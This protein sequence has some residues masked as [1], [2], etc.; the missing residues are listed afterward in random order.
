M[1]RRIVLAAL[2][3]ALFAA[4]CP[5]EESS[6]PPGKGA[7]EACFAAHECRAGL[8]CSFSQC[9]PASI[10]NASCQAP[11]ISLGAEV[12]VSDPGLCVTP[13]RTPVLA[14]DDRGPLRVTTPVSFDVAPGT[15]SLTIFSQEIDNTAADSIDL[16]GSQLPNTVVPTGVLRPPG[17]TLFF[18][19]TDP[20][21]EDSRHYR[22]ATGTLAFYAGFTPTMSAFTVPNTS[23]ALDLVRS[24]GELPSGTW[25]FTV[26]DWAL[27]CLSLGGCQGGS[28]Q[29][30]YRVQIF[31][32]S[33][34]FRS[35]GTLDLEVYVATDPTMSQLRSAWEAVHGGIAPQISRWVQGIAAYY[36]RAGVCI[37]TVTFHD[38]P[39]WAKQRFAPGG[40][41]DV[42]Q[43]GQCSPLSQLFTLGVAQKTAVHL[44]LTDEL[45][46]GPI[47]G[48]GRVLGVD[49]AIPGPSGVPGTITS[50]AVMG[51]FDLLGFER[52]GATGACTGASSLSTCGTDILSYVAAHEA[53]HW[54]G[55]YHT[56]EMTG[57]HFDPLSDTPL[58]QCLSCAP[59]ATRINCWEL[60]ASSSFQV[61]EAAFCTGASECGG[62]RNLM[63]WLLDDD[64][65]A[66]ELTPE[67]GEVVR[68]NPAI[69]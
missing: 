31:T 57:A 60:N 16:G 51:L 15:T 41:V 46:A 18:S 50:G 58:C 36:A 23:A 35:P 44:F 6:T 28:D 67:Q 65:S 48:G 14:V 30:T 4:G 29:G 64:L 68:L 32:S 5:S 10:P 7:G 11:V 17:S 38:L 45:F 13:V 62:A 19:D 24:A 66:G 2:P 21:P 12:T 39:L 43:E 61:M 69:H 37:G 40:V 56:T 8:V 54:L 59:L 52:G 42:S 47:T 49:G 55:L 33:R 1:S 34:D 22:D 27:E 25:T 20:I 9:A 26:N 3:L 63:Y 53:G